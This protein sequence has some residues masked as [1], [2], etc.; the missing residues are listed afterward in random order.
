[1]KRSAVVAAAL[2][3][4]AA[5]HAH[6]LIT[7]ESADR[8]LQQASKW[9]ALA[10]SS[11]SA[12]GRAESQYRIGTLLD[13]IRELLNR[14]LA[15]HGKVQGLP[16][17]YLLAEL[18]RHGTPLVWSAQQ[19]R[20]SAN[21]PY[22]EQ[23]LALAPRGPHAADAGLR[24]LQGGF[25][26][27]FETDPLAADEPWP[28]LARQL[29]L[30]EDLLARQLQGEAREEIE[31]IGAILHTRASLRAP[32]VATRRSHGRKARAMISAFK[33]RHPDSLRSAV[34]PILGAVLDKNWPA[35]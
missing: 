33:A 4:A 27:S 31:F 1:M 19:R 11:A 9:Q 21:T 32:D 35:P 10:T 3:T 34:M 15:A 20:Y 26:D 29:A 7:A 5:A 12:V 8:Y 18:Q 13:E 6:D 30:A 17:N 2:L 25:Y 24:L 22:F 28:Q 23:A 14:D 16:S